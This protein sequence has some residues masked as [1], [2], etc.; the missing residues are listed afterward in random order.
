MSVKVE[1][2]IYVFHRKYILMK[3]QVFFYRLLRAFNSYIQAYTLLFVCLPSNN[4][5][6]TYLR[7]DH[8]EQSFQYDS[9]ISCV[10]FISN[11]YMKCTKRISKSYLLY[12]LVQR[13]VKID[14]LFFLLYKE[15]LQ[16]TC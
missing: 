4:F 11:I 10:I 3:S 16:I 2:K 15:T 1:N 14:I 9:S 8:N 5:H 7:S 13:L 12:P 6:F